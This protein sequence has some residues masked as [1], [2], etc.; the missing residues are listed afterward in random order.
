MTTTTNK[1]DEI[2][3]RK[4]IWWTFNDRIRDKLG[5]KM[6]INENDEFLY[7]QNCKT[8][9]DLLDTR[10]DNYKMII[11]ELYRNIG[12]F[13]KSIELIDNIIVDFENT[14]DKNVDKLKKI[15]E[16]CLLKNKLVVKSDI[17]DI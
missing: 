5:E 16:E 10:N 6:F 11:A 12:N 8:L 14:N 7:I 9:I 13:E 17:F 2:F 1:D 15:K 4:K 3:I